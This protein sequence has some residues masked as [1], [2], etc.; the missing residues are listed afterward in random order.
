[1]ECLDFGEAYASVEI[2]EAIRIL[3]AYDCAHT[4][5]LYQM[6]VRSAVLN[7]YI[8]KLVFFE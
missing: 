7:G 6:N 5:K 3:M 1:M 4:V 2:L 8:N